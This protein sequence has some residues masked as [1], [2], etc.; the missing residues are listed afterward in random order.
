MDT[1]KSGPSMGRTVLLLIFAGLLALTLAGA[2]AVN[3]VQSTF[4]DREF[5]KDQL[6]REPAYQAAYTF[7]NQS[8]SSQ[9]NGRS[10]TWATLAGISLDEIAP[11]PY[12]RAQLAGMV[13]GLFDYIEG[14]AATA[15]LVF[16]LREPKANLVRIAQERAP[17]IWQQM[18]AQ[19]NSDV[20]DEVDLS[21]QIDTASLAQAKSARESIA[22][23]G[24]G[25]WVASLILLIVIILIGKAYPAHAMRWIGIALLLAGILTFILP[26]VVQSQAGPL[27]SAQASAGESEGRIFMQTILAEGV[28]KFSQ[29][30][31]IPAIIVALIGIVLLAASFLVKFDNG[32]KRAE[33]KAT[34]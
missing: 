16:D 24:M 3:T 7:F 4:M 32:E 15:R 11:R 23:A 1:P 5:Y 31:T 25:L 6:D 10:D 21:T 20:P 9:T 27:L 29:N 30:L 17:A 14:K 26:G 8:L 13:D 22:S 28:Q 34:H 12:V 18:E 19:I 2:L 33:K